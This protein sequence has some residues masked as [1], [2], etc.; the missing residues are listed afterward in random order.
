MNN[1]NESAY[2]AQELD[3]GGMPRTAAQW[4]LTKREL[5]AAMAM[6]GWCASDGNSGAV[7]KSFEDLAE[8]SVKA[9]DALLAELA[10][11]PK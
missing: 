7:Y 6:Q 1:G 5:F 2:P 11:E 9:A 3:G 4:G 8:A 10:E